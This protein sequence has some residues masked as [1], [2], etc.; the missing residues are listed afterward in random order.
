MKENRI[1][2]LK[3]LEFYGYHGVL[4]E[5]RT[6]GQR[7]LVDVDIFLTT[8]E[9]LWIDELTSTVNYAE[10][11]S[12]VKNCVEIEQF[13]LI[14]SLAEEICTRLLERFDCRAI[15][16]EIHKPNAPIPGVVRD[17]SIEITR[18]KQK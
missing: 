15:R 2:H 8:D 6:I 13:K 5:E 14:E 9:L 10:V 17:I 4:E 7:F 16:V 11:F 12:V 1:I 3:G 18:K